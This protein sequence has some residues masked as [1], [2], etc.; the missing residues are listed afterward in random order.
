MKFGLKTAL[1][2]LSP[3]M[4]PYGGLIPGPAGNPDRTAYAGQP[5]ST[6]DAAA[7]PAQPAAPIAY[8]PLAPL[9]APATTPANA[10]VPASVR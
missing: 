10:P 7:N 4:V 2:V 9:P 3:L 1:L 5:G 8:N 6:Y